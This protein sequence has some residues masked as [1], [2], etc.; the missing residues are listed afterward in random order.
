MK[1]LSKGLRNKRALEILSDDKK[2]TLT[3]PGATLISFGG[4]AGIRCVIHWNRIGALFSSYRPLVAGLKIFQEKD[5]HIP[6]VFKQRKRFW[7]PNYS[8]TVWFAEGLNITEHKQVQ[9]DTVIDEISITNTTKTEM[10]LVLFFHGE[11]SQLP[12]FDYYEKDKPPEAYVQINAKEGKIIITQYHI[13]KGLRDT[14]STQTVTFTKSFDSAGFYLDEGDLES[15]I[16]NFGCLASLR[17]RLGQVGARYLLAEEK[18]ISYKHIKPCY[19]CGVRMKIGAGKTKRITVFSRYEVNVEGRK[20]EGKKVIRLG[21]AQKF[22]LSNSIMR[23]IRSWEKYFKESCPDFR[24]DDTATEKFWY[25]V[26]YVLRANRCERGRHIKHAF[27]SPSKYFY[28]GV[29]IWDTYFHSLGERWLKDRSIVEESIKAVL[30]MRAPNGYIPCC[31]GS[32]MRMLFSGKDKIRYVPGVLRNY[33]EEKKFY[34]AKFKYYS[35][36]DWIEGVSEEITQTPLIACA[37]FEYANIHNNWNFAR[38]VFPKILSYEKW[39]WRR[40]TDKFGRFIG[41]HG[42]ESGWDDATRHYPAPF[43]PVDMTVHAY[44]HRRDLALIAEKLGKIGLARELWRRT[45]ITADAI[46]SLWSNEKGCYLDRDGRNRV[47]PQIAGSTFFPMWARLASPEQAKKLVKLLLSS[48]FNTKFPVPTLATSDRDYNPHGWGWNGTVWLQVNWFIIEGLFNYGYWREAM[49]L[50]EKTKALII[51]DGKPAS[52]E[53]Y[54]PE[55]GSGIGAPDYSWQALVN[56]FIV[57]RIVGLNHNF[58]GINFCPLLG[59]GMKWAS[60][61]GLLIGDSVWNIELEEFG[62]KML[63]RV[64]TEKPQVIS[65]CLWKRGKLKE[66]KANGSE[67]KC[68]EDET[69]YYALTQ[70]KLKN[71]LI[72][73]WH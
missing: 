55:T 4:G 69:S 3:E 7:L 59:K 11:V 52:C 51:K 24:C 65:I 50:W 66:V 23:N 6:L 61:K 8:Q 43:K 1:N 32:D 36:G 27:D 38:E 12:F 70:L 64:E 18:L 16:E 39:I 53:L 20:N 13:F 2:S 33:C 25:Y 46:Q 62:K 41:R 71:E 10:R 34:L 40:R 14:F 45:R 26:W 48:E 72:V 21:G 37:V 42:V 68:A 29:W 9:K 67:L 56:D 15:L 30:D 19:Y 47:R 28:W 35:G 63:I 44:R 31:S 54:D 57:R 17:I 49:E 22:D 73:E 58:G 60:L 5:L